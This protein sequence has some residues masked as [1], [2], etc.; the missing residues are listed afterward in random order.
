MK[1]WLLPTNKLH[2]IWKHVHFHITSSI[3]FKQHDHYIAQFASNQKRYKFSTTNKCS[4]TTTDL[5]L[6]T[7]PETHLKEN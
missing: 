7:T 3:Y 6:N 5:Q 1:E 2:I 4:D